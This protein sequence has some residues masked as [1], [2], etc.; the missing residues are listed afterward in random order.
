MCS[1]QPVLPPIC[2]RECQGVSPPRLPAWL[3]R[4]RSRLRL[5]DRNSKS[6]H[7]PISDPLVRSAKRNFLQQGW[8]WKLL[9]AMLVCVAR[10]AKSNRPRARLITGRGPRALRSAKSGISSDPRRAHKI[11]MR[12][13]KSG[14][15]ISCTCGWQSKAASRG[16]AW[17]CRQEHEQFPQPSDP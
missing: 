12:S 4:R 7:V 1:D 11:R 8:I 15:T 9:S 6:G 5:P 13:T 2:V 10:G 16:A 3:P 14:W 17:M